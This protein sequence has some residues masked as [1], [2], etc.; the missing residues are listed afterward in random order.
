MEKSLKLYLK[1]ISFYPLLSAKDEKDLAKRKRNGGEEA[2]DAKNKLICCNLR[3]VITIAKKFAGR[4][5]DFGDLLE[6]GN[7][8][9]MEAVKKYDGRKGN[10]F[11]T[12]AGW[13]IRVY[14]QK[15]L[16]KSGATKIPFYFNAQISKVAKAENCLNG[17]ND[18]TFISKI[19]EMTGLS[20]KEVIKTRQVMKFREPIFLNQKIKETENELIDFASDEKGQDTESDLIKEI[21]LRNKL[22]WTLSQFSLRDRKII[23]LK[24]GYD[25]EDKNGFCPQKYREIAE[26]TGLT[27]GGVHHIYWKIIEEMRTNKKFQVLRELYD[28]Y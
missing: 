4:G 22:N 1:E 8:G 24:I 11:A 27:I 19:A 18:S 14:I 20:E 13:W 23:C 9:L 10:R 26:E 28:A 12:Y 17:E 3:L 21:D 25:P 6:A 5:L 16:M 15:A 2:R 7:D